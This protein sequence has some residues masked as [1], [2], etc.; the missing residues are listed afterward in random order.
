MKIKNRK[1]IK[2][3]QNKKKKI[4]IINKIYNSKMIKN[5]II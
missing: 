4:T 2:T 5:K 1:I 3:K